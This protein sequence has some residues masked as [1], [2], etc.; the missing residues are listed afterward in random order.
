MAMWVSISPMTVK[1]KCKTSKTSLHSNPFPKISFGRDTIIDFY[2]LH[3]DKIQ[4]ARNLN[5]F[6]ARAAR[7]PTSDD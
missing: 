1:L 7:A 4:A 3:L 6:Q 2:F 5:F